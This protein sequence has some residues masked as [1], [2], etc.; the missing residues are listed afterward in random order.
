VLEPQAVG[1]LQCL[2]DVPY[3]SRPLLQLQRGPHLGELEAL[4]VL[5]EEPGRISFPELQQPNDSRI[6]EQGEGSGLPEEVLRR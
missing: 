4:D 6:V 3:D 2:R 5:E 1:A